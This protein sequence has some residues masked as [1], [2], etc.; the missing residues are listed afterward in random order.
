MGA[1]VVVGVSLLAALVVIAAL[2]LRRRTRL[3]SKRD[4]SPE[5]RYRR[6]IAQLRPD[7]DDSWRSRRYGRGGSNNAPSFYP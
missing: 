7:S 5:D 6:D 4:L 1:A 3:H 2:V